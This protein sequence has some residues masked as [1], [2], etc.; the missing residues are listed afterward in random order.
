MY[1]AAICNH[2]GKNQT[3]YRVSPKNSCTQSKYSTSKYTVF[4]VCA[5]LI[6]NPRVSGVLIPQLFTADIV[7][8][9][10][11]H[12]LLLIAHYLHQL[13]TTSSKVLNQLSVTDTTHTSSTSYVLAQ[14]STADNATFKFLI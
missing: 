1:F 14:L 2:R 3:A 8:F 5:I 10:I 7:H 4:C 6:L 12:L 13:S 9:F 11:N